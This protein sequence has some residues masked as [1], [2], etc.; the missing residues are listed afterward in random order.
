MSH[1]VSLL[2]SRHLTFTPTR[3]AEDLH[4]PEY[5]MN[6]SVNACD[7]VPGDRAGGV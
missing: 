7:E 1:K 6:A 4:E 5:R 3:T 2:R